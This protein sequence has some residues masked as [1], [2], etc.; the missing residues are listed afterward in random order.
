[1]LCNIVDHRK[2]KYR[3][4]Q[5]D[6]VIEATWHDNKNT[7][8]DQAVVIEDDTYVMCEDR[9]GVSVEEAVAWAVA[10]SCPVTLFLYD[11]GSLSDKQDNSED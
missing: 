8:A 3:W 6:A 1:M 9:L 7:D 10:V 2:R 4:A 11:G 5:V